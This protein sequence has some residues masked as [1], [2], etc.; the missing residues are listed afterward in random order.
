M[1]STERRNEKTTHIDKASTIEAL[2]IIN[3]ENMNSVNA[4]G[5]AIE[6]I[7]KAID[8]IVVAMQNGGR[9]IYVGA[10]TSGRLASADA[11]E[12]PP[13][14]GVDYNTVI[15]VVAGGPSALVRASENVEDFIPE[16]AIHVTIK[17]SSDGEAKREI[18]IIW[19]GQHENFSL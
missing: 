12:C 6:D 11:A 18:E 16:Y 9:L 14:F 8:A 19:D 4:V 3:Q 15:A 17:R 2:R 10:G 5:N 13:T 7:A 1:I